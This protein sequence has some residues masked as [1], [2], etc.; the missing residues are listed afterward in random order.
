MEYINDINVF[1]QRINYSNVPIL[2]DFYADW[3]GPCK[4]I[5]PVFEGLK[6]HFSISLIKVNV[7]NAPEIAES[8]DIQAM[9]TFLLFNKGKV[10]DK[11]EGADEKRLVAMVKKNCI[12][13]TV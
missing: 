12:Q 5:A 10:I 7:D 3:C 6:S 1:I 13:L 4:K 9:P 11:L 2:I 8:Y